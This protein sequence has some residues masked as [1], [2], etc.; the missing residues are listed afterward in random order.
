MKTNSIIL[1]I[2]IS[3]LSLKTSQMFQFPVYN[4]NN[5]KELKLDVVRWKI[6][7]IDDK[8]YCLLE[9]RQKLVKET[10]PYK[11]GV[12]DP[13]RE[14]AI[15]ARLQKK[16]NELDQ[17]FVKQI[18]VNIFME[19]CKIQSAEISSQEDPSDQ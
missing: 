5:L 16:G 9:K 12:R 11:D 6:D 8:L 13:L 10:T 19:S 17:N 1:C 18:W 14:V 3:L 4:F 2:I 7:Q 15:L